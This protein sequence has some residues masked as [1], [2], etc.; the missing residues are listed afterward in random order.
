M[1]SV[2]VCSAL[3]CMHQPLRAQNVV[4]YVGRDSSLTGRWSWALAEA[5]RSPGKGEFWVGYSI[6][7]LMDEDAYILS[8]SVFSGSVQQDRPNLYDVIEGKSSKAIVTTAWRSHERPGIFKRLKDVAVLF[9]FSDGSS[10]IPSVDRIDLCTMELSVD[11]QKKPLYWLGFADDVESVRHLIGVFSQPVS[12]DVKKRLVETIAIHQHSDDVYPF[13]VSVLEG[14]EQDG[15]RARA[16]FWI[17]EQK[18]P[19]SLRLLMETAQ[20]D[21]SR[22]VREE[23]VFAISQTDGDSSVDALITLA[24]SANDAKVRSKAAFWLGQKTS[25]KAVATLEDIIA[26]DEDTDVQRQALYG[27]SQIKDN[28]AVNRLIRVAKSHPNPRIRKL[29]IQILGQTDDP[30]ALEAL[31]DIARN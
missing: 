9:L 7:R 30:K 5:H 14:S 8:G 29:A 27:L 15:V 18:N 10:G 23:S 16:A 22:K 20:Q 21:R 6:K 26:G 24:R 2:L 3:L 12:I 4:G 1:C 19:E 28:E 11:L 25:T 31:I 13:L 17:G